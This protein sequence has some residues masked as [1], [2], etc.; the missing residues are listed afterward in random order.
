[1]LLLLLLLVVV[2]LLNACP[3]NRL[4]QREALFRNRHSKEEE[5]QPISSSRVGGFVW[6]RLE[7]WWLCVVS[8]ALVVASLVSIAVGVG[9]VLSDA[10][11]HVMCIKRCAVLV[12]C[13]FSPPAILTPGNPPSALS[14]PPQRI[15]LPRPIE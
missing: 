7:D 6:L 2:V 12:P 15:K 14:V 8:N 10:L 9:G 13:A 5:A 3:D 4:G 11:C 1:M